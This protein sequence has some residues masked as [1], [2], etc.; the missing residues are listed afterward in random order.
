MEVEPAEPDAASFW[1]LREMVSE[2]EHAYGLAC[3][4]DIAVP[5][6][7]LADFVVETSTKIRALE[8]K[9][10]LFIFGHLAEGNLHYNVGKPAALAQ[11]S[12]GRL[13]S[14]NAAH[15]F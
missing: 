9:A 13:V 11:A 10:E 14:A 6:A 8:N 5:P 4:H 7:R 2:A 15:R 3:K 12:F 1:R